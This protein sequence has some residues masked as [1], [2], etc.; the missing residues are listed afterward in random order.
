M[1]SERREKNALRSPTRDHRAFVLRFRGRFLSR[2][3]RLGCRCLACLAGLGFHISGGFF[4]RSALLDNLLSHGG[5]V[6]RGQRL[7]SWNAVF[8]SV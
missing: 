2:F 3:A 6:F 7:G 5:G 4:P 8:D 1:G